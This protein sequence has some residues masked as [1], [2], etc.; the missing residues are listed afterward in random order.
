MNSATNET[1]RDAARRLAASAIAQGFKPEALH[2]YRNADGAPSFWRIR[3]KHANGEKWMRPMRLNGHGYELKEPDFPNGRPLY[4]LDEIVASPTAGVWVCEGEKAADALRRLGVIATTSG[5]AQS[6]AGA[7]WT[8]LARRT[9]RLWP[10]NDDAGRAYVGEVAK[11]LQQIGCKVCVVDIGALGLSSKEDA[12]DWLHAHQ[13]AM[14]ADLE[15]LPTIAYQSDDGRAS[16]MDLDGV[17]GWPAPLDSA[18]FHGIAG[19]F[20]RAVEPNTESDPAAI[21]VQFL[22]AFGALVGRGP[23]Y[24][25]ERTEHHA[26]LYAV[27]V[28]PTAKARKGTSWDHVADVF[29][30]IPEWKPT[31]SGLSSGEG[32]IHAVRDPIEKASTN[33]HGDRVTEVVDGGVDDKRLLVKEPEFAT[34]LRQ[35]QR[36]GN[37]LSATLRE[38]WDSGNL[39]TLTKNTPETATGAHICIVGHITANELRA[40][41]AQ[42]DASNGFANRFLFV[43]ARRSKMLPFGGGEADE[44]KRQ[45]MAARL[46]ERMLTARTGG[47][48][49]MSPDACLVWERVYPELSRGGDGLHGSV[50]AR[51]EAH[52]ARLAMVY[53][54]LDGA[55]EI[56]TPHLLAALAVWQYCD[57]TARHVFGPSL[58][59]RI[60]DELF[61]RLQRASATGM[62]RSEIYDSF[63]RHQSSERIGAALELLHRNG[64]A[65]RE[66][67]TTGGRPS[68]VWRTTL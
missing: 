54:L 63:G 27:L 5:G 44:A 57:A 43:A 37:I 45:A 30:R 13:D 61:R 24:R 22:V 50:T 42:T 68:E 19:E 2:E 34:A 39:R 51:A 32:V 25:V 11:L 10:D 46:R 59:D 33:K 8:P 15:A 36:S 31:V 14:Q 66:I 26:N 62:T 9:V 23:H 18:A 6:A 49:G 67:V 41:L 16:G 65:K 17:V 53:C 35:A 38:G 58:G 29:S 3:L 1:P 7:H 4:H 12:W 48:I 52:T 47:R 60:A 20:V 55:T 56:G 64:V 21:L 28:G 40:D